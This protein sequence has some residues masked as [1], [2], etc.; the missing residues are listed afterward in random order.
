MKTG[1]K[2]RYPVVSVASTTFELLEFLKKHHGGSITNKKTYKE[3]HTPSGVWALRGAM[4]IPFIADILPFLVISEKK[5]RAEMI[6]NEYNQVTPRNGKYTPEQLLAKQEF[7]KKF[8][9]P[10]IP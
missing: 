9:H 6:I 5:R 4:C 1:A 10:S 8:F 3:H 7:E 2:F